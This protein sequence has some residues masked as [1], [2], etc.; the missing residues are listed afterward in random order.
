MDKIRMYINGQEISE[1]Q[2]FEIKRSW[3]LLEQ[4]KNDIVADFRKRTKLGKE[5]QTIKDCIANFVRYA[6][7]NG[8]GIVPIKLPRKAKKVFKKM[9]GHAPFMIIARGNAHDYLYYE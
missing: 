9:Y 3:D 5:Q 2:E 6:Q 1:T 8:F 4:I 7:R